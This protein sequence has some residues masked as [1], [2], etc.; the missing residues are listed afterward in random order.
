VIASEMAGPKY[1]LIGRPISPSFVS[2]SHT[3]LIKK[4]EMC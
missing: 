3:L 4:G 1:W 2:C